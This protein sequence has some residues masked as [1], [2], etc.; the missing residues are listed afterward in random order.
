MVADT[1]TAF[2]WLAEHEINADRMGVVGFDLGGSVALLRGGQA[3][4]RRRGHRRADERRRP[5]AA[6]PSLV[7]ARA[8]LTCPWL[9]IY[10]ANARRTDPRD[11]PA[12][13]RA[14]AS[15]VVTDVVVYPRSGHR[16]DDDP[17]AAADAWQRTLNWFDS[18]LR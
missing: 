7:A 6:S 18:H 9:G 10:G 13:R 17:E 16:F 12:A 3:H 1:D 8:G 5:R 14:A 2:G 11:R 4:A 15:E